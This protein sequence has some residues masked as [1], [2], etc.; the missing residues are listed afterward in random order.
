[1]TLTSTE[2]QA[3]LRRLKRGPILG[4]A[5]LAAYVERVKREVV[6]GRKAGK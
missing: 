1:M 6:A 2:R 4:R 3:I 5:A